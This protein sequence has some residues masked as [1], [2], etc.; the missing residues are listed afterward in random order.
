M[1]FTYCVSLQHKK[2]RK[3]NA[4]YVFVI[5]ENRTRD[6]RVTVPAA[7]LV[8][9]YD[10]PAEDKPRPSV[11]GYPVVH[12]AVAVIENPDYQGGG[13]RVTCRW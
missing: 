13:Q 11:V 2:K 10:W 12:R 3:S 6:P 9:E 1:P 7:H 8:A 5:S 4:S